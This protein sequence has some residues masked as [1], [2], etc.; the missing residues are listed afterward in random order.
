MPPDFSQ[1][2]LAEIATLRK[3]PALAQKI[4]AYEP[5]PPSPME[6]Q[7]QQL[8][9]MMTQ[10]Q[11]Q[12]MQIDAYKKQTEA[13][14]NEADVALKTAKT[15]SEYVNQGLTQSETDIN[16]LVFLDTESGV[17]HARSIDRIKAQAKAQ[18]EMK[19][20]EAGLEVMKAR[21]IPKETK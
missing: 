20:V 9:M 15:Q 1:L 8:Q 4:A 6:Q 5:P 21:K 3:M 17:D 10:M 11:L 14:E 12:L 18:T 16:N 19:I 13:A 7:M 2:V